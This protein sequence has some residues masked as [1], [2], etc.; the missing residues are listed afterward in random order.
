MHCS[1]ASESQ[2]SNG[3]VAVGVQTPARQASPVV[4]CWPSSHAVPSG[5][6]LPT[7]RPVAGWQAPAVWQESVA[8]GQTTGAPLTQVPDWQLSPVVQ[9]LLSVQLVPL[10]AAGFEQVPEAASQ[11]PATWHESKAVQVLV[12]PPEQTPA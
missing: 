9:A 2:W 11:V 3:V 4:H 1:Q 7:H 6:V 8:G 12:V 5:A 10:A